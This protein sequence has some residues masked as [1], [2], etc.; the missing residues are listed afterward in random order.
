MPKVVA[1]LILFAANAFGQTCIKYGAPATL[2]GTLLLKD[3]AGY[4]QF[5]SLKPVRAICV[6]VDPKEGDDANYP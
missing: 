1:F 6:E 2:T 5:I 4:N 3:E